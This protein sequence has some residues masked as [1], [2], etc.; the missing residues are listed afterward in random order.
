MSTSSI[1]SSSSSLSSSSSGSSPSSSHAH[2]INVRLHY[3]YNRRASVPDTTVSSSSAPN[4]GENSTRLT[5]GRVRSLPSASLPLVPLFPAV[6]SPKGSSTPTSLVYSSRISTPNADYYTMQNITSTRTKSAFSSFLEL[7]PIPTTK[8][9]SQIINPV[10]LHSAPDSG[11]GAL[12][13]SS[14]SSSSD[15]MM[16]SKS[17]TQHGM[18]PKDYKQKE[19]R[20]KNRHKEYFI[21]W[22]EID[23]LVKNA[24]RFEKSPESQD[25]NKAHECWKQAIVLVESRKDED[26]TRGEMYLLGIG[27]SIAR[28][29]KTIQIK[30]V[31]D[32]YT[33]TA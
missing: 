5:R 14:S 26:Q 6:L 22:K 8:R 12:T 11:I 23:D 24:K 17:F 4:L 3:S 33:T 25:M 9:T 32:Q 16:G 29:K 15:V 10:V 31:L 28:L 18:E 2:P 1:P 13:S 21:A 30:K 27:K 20:S 19:I 7:P